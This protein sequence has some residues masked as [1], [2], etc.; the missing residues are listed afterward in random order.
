MTKRKKSEA[1]IAGEIFAKLLKEDPSGV[2]SLFDEYQVTNAHV[3]G[4]PGEVFL[5][6]KRPS[7][8]VE[9]RNIPGKLFKIYKK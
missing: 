2:M 4:I 8:G 5:T 7:T 1:L 9:I 6:L 3:R